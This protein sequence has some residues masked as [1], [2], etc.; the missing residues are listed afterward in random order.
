MTLKSMIKVHV[1]LCEALI[2]LLHSDLFFFFPA[3]KI[4]KPHFV[5]L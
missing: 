2:L 3:S 4:M 5:V 1:F